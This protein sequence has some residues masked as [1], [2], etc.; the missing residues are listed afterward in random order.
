MAIT[1]AR[2]R[3]NDESGALSDLDRA[4]EIDP[5]NVTALL[6]R[7]VLL[8][9]KLRLNEARNDLRRALEID[10]SKRSFAQPYLDRMKR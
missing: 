6:G 9:H 3:R 7:G 1:E 8:F 2:S 10:P 5:D 4:I